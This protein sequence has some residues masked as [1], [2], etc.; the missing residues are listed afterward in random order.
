MIY[1]FDSNASDRFMATAILFMSIGMIGLIILTLAGSV[2]ITYVI[3]KAIINTK[4]HDY[5]IF[6]T[7]GAN[8]KA[9]N[10]FIY[11]ENLYVVLVAFVIFV[12][13]N[14]SIPSGVKDFDFLL[15]LQMFNFLSYVILLFLLVIMSLLV[16]RRYCNKIFNQSV[17]S[18]LKTDVG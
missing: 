11:I 5:A 13:V 3:F 18:A 14:L 16:S 17:Q 15:P 4:L 9:I 1:P 7:I 12:A 6:R 10:I 8:K 2:L